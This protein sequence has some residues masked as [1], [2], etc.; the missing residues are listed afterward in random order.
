MDLN[1]FINNSFI[2]NDHDKWLNLYQNK[3]M[4]TYLLLNDQLIVFIANKQL[5]S[6]IKI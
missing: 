4:S 1:T 3:N 2:C 5:E 6:P